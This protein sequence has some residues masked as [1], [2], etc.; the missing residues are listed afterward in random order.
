[1]ISAPYK[2]ISSTLDLDINKRNRQREPIANASGR[3]CGLFS[4]L[5]AATVIAAALIIWRVS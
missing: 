3:K 2:L 4:L 5:V 1:M